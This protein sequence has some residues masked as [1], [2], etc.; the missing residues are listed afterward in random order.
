MIVR[1]PVS[2]PSALTARPQP[3]AAIRAVRAL[4]RSLAIADGQDKCHVSIASAEKIGCASAVR[5]KKII[6]E[7]CMRAY[8]K[9]A[10]YM[11]AY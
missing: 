8:N 1:G 9:L 6:A 2:V 4:S 11:P 7:Y 3:C 5:N 10:E